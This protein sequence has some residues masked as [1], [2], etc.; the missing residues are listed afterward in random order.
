MGRRRYRRYR[1]RYGYRRRR[2]SPASYVAA[3]FAVVAVAF[4]MALW[5]G[6]VAVP[7]LDLPR[8]P[9][10]PAVELP[11]MDLPDLPALIPLPP[12]AASPP[13]LAPAPPPAPN[14]GP[15]A[16]PPAPPPAPPALPPPAP[17]PPPSPPAG[18]TSGLDMALVADIVYEIVNAE[19]ESRGLHAISRDADLDRISYM[20]SRDMAE[21]GYFEHVSPDGLDPTGRGRAAGYECVNGAY[22]GLW[23]NIA[24]V[25]TYWQYYVL[26]D[27]STYSWYAGEAEFAGKIMDVW[28]NS[29]GHRDNILR[30]SHVSV[31]IGIHVDA[32]EEAFATQNFC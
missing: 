5:L 2:R 30:G 26:G 18:A 13:D 8:F 29:P 19:R 9:D 31:G 20:H 27:P 14:P 28:M 25:P 12:P 3:T 6:L 24:R 17:S 11:P 15:P 1:P 4:G 22:V 10:L 7:G 23:E 32:Y 21:R 16:A